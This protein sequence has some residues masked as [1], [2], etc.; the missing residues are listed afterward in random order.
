MEATS[1]NTGIAFAAIGR[2][3]GHPVTVFMPDWMSAERKSLILSF[4]AEVV[5]VSS[6]QG[7]FLGAIRLAEE[8]AEQNPRTF[9]PRQFSNQANTEAHALMTGP[10]IWLPLRKPALRPMPSWR[11]WERGDGD[12]RRSLPA[13]QGSQHSGPPCRTRGSPTLTTGCKVGSHRI[14][15][16]SDEFIPPIVNLTELNH[17][18]AI[19]DGDSILM[20]QNLPGNWAL[21]WV[22]HPAA[23]SWRP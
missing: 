22:F 13:E 18:I 11:A 20:A 17:V 10:E 14:Q 6:E 9:L 5:P 12:G 1:G 3:L 23:I 8:M 15:G 2:A 7:G 21:A 16:I 19:P 4:G